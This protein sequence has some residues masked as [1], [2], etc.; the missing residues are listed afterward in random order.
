MTETMFNPDLWTNTWKEVDKNSTKGAAS[1]IRDIDAIAV[2]MTNNL[3]IGRDKEDDCSAFNGGN[4]A[5]CKFY[6]FIFDN[7]L[8]THICQHLLTLVISIGLVMACEKRRLQLCDRPYVF[9][10]WNVL[11]T[12]TVLNEIIEKNKPTDSVI[13]PESTWPKAEYPDDAVS[14]YI[15]Y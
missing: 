6:S 14:G 3:L 4:S 15:Y 10:Q 11:K 7:L 8:H 5:V 2:R 9:P 13:I 1:V 12:D